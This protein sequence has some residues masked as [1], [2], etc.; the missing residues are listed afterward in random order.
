MRAIGLVSVSFVMT[1]LLATDA[2]SANNRWCAVSPKKSEN[3]KSWPR[4]DTVGDNAGARPAPAQGR[5][6]ITETGEI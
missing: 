2:K 4:T 5:L 3:C 1:T 6:D